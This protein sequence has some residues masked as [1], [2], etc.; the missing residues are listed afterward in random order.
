MWISF[1]SD[2]FG[3]Q[4]LAGRVRM[5]CW[6]PWRPGRGWKRCWLLRQKWTRCRRG[7]WRALCDWERHGWREQILDGSGCQWIKATKIRWDLVSTK[8]APPWPLSVWVRTDWSGM[9]PL[10]LH[11]DYNDPTISCH[12]T[13]NCQ[14]QRRRQSSQCHCYQQHQRT[15]LDSI[16]SIGCLYCLHCIQ[17][18]EHRM[19]SVLHLMLGQ[20]CT[21]VMVFICFHCT[22]L[23]FRVPSIRLCEGKRNINKHY[24]SWNIMKY[25]SQTCEKQ[26]QI[27]SIGTL[28]RLCDVKRV[29]VNGPKFEGS[30]TLPTIVLQSHLVL[31]ESSWKMLQRSANS[32]PEMGS[33]ISFPLYM[34]S[35]RYDRSS[36]IFVLAK[37][38]KQRWKLMKRDCPV[39]GSLSSFT[40]H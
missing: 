6:R 1:V 21:V 20:I 37:F 29:D 18:F 32:D 13:Q 11:N 39:L 8:H 30:K 9:M 24:E 14:H 7:T 5:R 3:V 16:G 4:V 12:H 31:N 33:S 40:S 22:F 28:C 19:D 17:D 15:S 23:A 35:F 36:N 2:L 26:R 25:Q 34:G 10:T 38:L 27:C